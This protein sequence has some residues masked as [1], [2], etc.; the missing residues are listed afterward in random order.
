MI[1]M[2]KKEV[3]FIFVLALLL[4][5]LSG[6]R[7]KQVGFV[8]DQPENTPV[9]VS[10]LGYQKLEFGFPL[11]WFISSPHSNVLFMDLIIDLLFWFLVLAG[12]WWAVKKL[13]T[14][15]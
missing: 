15:K 11:A 9:V 7:I 13:K 6:L 10:P 2:K 12:G 1:V 14:K 8:S 5:F 3:L 4:T